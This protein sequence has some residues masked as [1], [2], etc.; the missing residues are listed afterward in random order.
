MKNIFRKILY[1]SLFITLLINT[2]VCDI[3]IQSIWKNLETPRE[4]K[5]FGSQWI[6][7]AIVTFKRTPELKEAIVINKLQFAWDGPMLTNLSAS[8]YK[9]SPNKDFLPTEDSLICDGKW[10]NTNQKLSFSFDD[11]RLDAVTRFYI[12]VTIP[13]IIANQLQEGSFNLLESSLPEELKQQSENNGAEESDTS[14]LLGLSFKVHPF[15][16]STSGQRS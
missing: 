4:T 14:L 2:K 7:A 1:C 13:D 6:L 12:V 9:K 15:I 11:E 10:N 3:T 5:L 16:E 8:L